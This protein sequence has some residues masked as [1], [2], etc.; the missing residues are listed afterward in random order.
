FFFSV[1]WAVL[2]YRA[3]LGYNTG[4]DYFGAL[5]RGNLKRPPLYFLG[6]RAYDVRPHGLYRVK[7]AFLIYK[8]IICWATPHNSRLAA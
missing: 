4:N 2:L 8:I 5:A 6:G 3:G 7:I 1:L